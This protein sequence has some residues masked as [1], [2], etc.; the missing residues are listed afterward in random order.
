M[1][2]CLCIFRNGAGHGARVGSS[3]ISIWF[4]FMISLHSFENRWKQQTSII[5]PDEWGIF[6]PPVEFLENLNP[7]KWSTNSSS[8]KWSTNSSSPTTFLDISDMSSVSEER[9]NIDLGT[10]WF[11][12]SLSYLCVSFSE[13]FDAKMPSCHQTPTTCSE[14]STPQIQAF[15][16]GCKYK[17]THIYVYIYMYIQIYI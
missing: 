13:V 14:K 11:P 2:R 5:L 1:T 9:G 16:G 7:H 6:K 4:H 8:P 17:Y 15:L 3:E 12:N 10:H